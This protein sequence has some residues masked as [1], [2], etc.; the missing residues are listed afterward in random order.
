MEEGAGRR[1]EGGR[2][3]KRVRDR[4]G[5]LDSNFMYVFHIR[6]NVLSAVPYILPQD[7]VS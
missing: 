6:F 2:E 5:P 3:G 4:T 7:F 1:R